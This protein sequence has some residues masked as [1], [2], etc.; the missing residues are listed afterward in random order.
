MQGNIQSMLGIFSGVVSQRRVAKALQQIAPHANELRACDIYK[1]TNPVPYFAP[2]FG[3]K[4]HMDQ[5]EKIAQSFGCTHATLIGGYSR[6]ICGYSS[7]E[8]E[9][10]I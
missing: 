3:Y 5:N 9:N 6:M 7:M 2:Y 1:R 10:P 8:F 4:V